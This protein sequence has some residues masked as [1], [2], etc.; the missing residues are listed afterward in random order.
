MPVD[1]CIARAGDGRPCGAPGILVDGQRGGM[2]CA[3]HAPQ[4]PLLRF[5]IRR[6][7]SYPDTFLAAAL[8]ELTDEALAAA[9]GCAPSVVWQ[10]RLARQPRPP[11][12]RPAWRDWPRPC[13]ARRGGSP[14]CSY[15]AWHWP[16]RN[17]AAPD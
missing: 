17:S 3:A 5:S 15:G 11:R 6:A 7:M 14:G 8:A 2:V 12:G 4:T 10:L 1:G 9:L 13:A 16:P